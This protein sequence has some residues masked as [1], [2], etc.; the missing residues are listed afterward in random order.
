MDGRVAP[1]RLP[2]T[3]ELACALE[4]DGDLFVLAAELLTAC[5]RKHS[6]MPLV[7]LLTDILSP[8]TLLGAI[9]TATDGSKMID[10]QAVVDF[11]TVMCGYSRD[12]AWRC[13]T[14][15]E[16]AL[17]AQRLGICSAPSQTRPDAAFLGMMTARHKD[18]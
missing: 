8:L 17:H 10:R 16:L 1:M 2:V 4:D 14:L 11:A 9:V 3:L 18:T 12:E 7:R 5:A 6:L 15:H 13:V